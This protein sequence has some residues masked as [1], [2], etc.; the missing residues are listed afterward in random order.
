MRKTSKQ[1]LFYI[2]P[3]LYIISAYMAFISF[4][5][6]ARVPFMHYFAFT[7]FIFGILNII[8][9]ARYCKPEYYNIMFNSCII[10][11]YCMVPFFI[12]GGLLVAGSFISGILIPV[13]PMFIIGFALAD[14]LCIAGWLVLAFE[15]PY[16]ISYLVLSQ[17]S[18]RRSKGMAVLHSILQFFF[19]ADVIDI[20]FL[21]FKDHKCVK[22]SIIFIILLSISII[23]LV[24][25]ILFILLQIII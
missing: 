17:K 13:P 20:I 6:E 3:V 24:L 7:P 4:F 2:F 23:A 5:T 22:A 11:K 8:M 25:I 18:G 15:A 19:T 21:S 14:T 12:A 1:R 10:V 16:A 9:A